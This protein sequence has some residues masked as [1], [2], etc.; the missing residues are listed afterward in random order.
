M[1]A[2]G[3]DPAALR[4]LARQMEAEAE[5]LSGALRSLDGR[6]ESTWWEG[7][8]ADRFRQAWADTHTLRVRRAV[9][10]LTDAAARLR[11]EAAQQDQASR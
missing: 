9:A 11:T 10:R 5:S 3:S 2:R 8:D 1:S 4:A 7:P 6:L